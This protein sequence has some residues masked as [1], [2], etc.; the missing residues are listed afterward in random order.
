MSAS[1]AAGDQVVAVHIK[2][3]EGPAVRLQG[4]AHCHVVRVPAPCQSS[5]NAVLLLFIIIFVIII[6]GEV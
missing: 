5:F 1:K 6:F 3:G 4:V 2:V